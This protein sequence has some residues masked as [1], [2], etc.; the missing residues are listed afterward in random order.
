MEK[1]RN[2][3]KH[4]SVPFAGQE[5]ETVRDRLLVLIGGRSARKAALDWGIS[6]S[7]LN[8]Y[9][10]RNTQP[11]LNVAYDICSIEGVSLE[12][13]AGGECEMFKVAK[14]CEPNKLENHPIST[15]NIEGLSELQKKWLS[16]FNYLTDDEAQNLIR[17]FHRKGI[18]TAIQQLL[19]PNNDSGIDSTVKAAL[20]AIDSL[21]TRNSLKGTLRALLL[22]GIGAGD[23]EIDKE[24]LDG[25][26]SLKRAKSPGAEDKALTPVLNEQKKIG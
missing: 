7:T 8:N 21:E 25:V 1:E 17:L 2:G 3:T 14:P 12:W 20:E 26:E 10:T 6:Y 23:S 9:L 22:M 5:K 19:A 13:F 4:K 16:I 18:E 15:S 24:I 11:S